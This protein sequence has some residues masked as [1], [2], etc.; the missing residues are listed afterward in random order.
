MRPRL[1]IFDFDGTLADSLTWFLGAY[2]EV[3]VSLGLRRIAPDEVPSLRGLQPRALLRHFGVPAWRVPQVAL[4]LRR[5]QARDIAQIQ[6]FDGVDAMLAQLAARGTLLAMVT[7][8]D[9]PNVRNVLGRHAR[10]F[11]HF[12]CG[13]AVLGKRAKLRQVLRA[14]R[15]A[16]EDALCIGDELRDLDAAQ[17]AGIPFAGVS[18]GFAD[19][20]AL[21]ASGAAAVFSSPA[22]ILGRLTA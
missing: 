20:A 9:V 22:D 1:I 16:P 21:R 19:P 13:A 12:A 14:S 17:Q 5:L 18:W 11:T 3:A 15:T 10:H 7:S 2:D 6:L 4:R 8:N